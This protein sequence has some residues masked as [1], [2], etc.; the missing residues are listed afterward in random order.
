MEAEKKTIGEILRQKKK[1]VI[2]GVAAFI[3]VAVC[4][5]L[6]LIR[7][8]MQ[9]GDIQGISCEAPKRF[10]ME[11]DNN[12]LTFSEQT[13]T[14]E[15][16]IYVYYKDTG[17]SL[18]EEG[19]VDSLRNSELY[20]DKS[21]AKGKPEFKRD[22]KSKITPSY[23]Y[24]NEDLSDKEKGRLSEFTLYNHGNGQVFVGITISGSETD[25]NN[26]KNIFNKVKDSVKLNEEESNK[27]VKEKTDI[28]ENDMSQLKNITVDSDIDIEKAKAS[29]AALN[30]KARE[31]LNSEEIITKAEK[32]YES[33]LQEAAAPAINA[34]GE[35]GKVTLKSK[36]AI[37][38]AEKLYNDLPLKVQQKVSNI[39]VMARA[40]EKHANLI[41][42]ESA[43]K[44][45]TAI[46]A[47]N[48]VTLDSK[49]AIEKAEKLYEGAKEEVKGKV[50]NYK[51]LAN[52]RDTYDSLLEK[53]EKEEEREKIIN[54]S[55]TPD[56]DELA[57]YPQKYEGQAV[58]IRGEVIQALDGVYRVNINH[59][60][61]RWTDTVYVTEA[62]DAD[63]KKLSQGSAAPVMGNLSLT[64]GTPAIGNMATATWPNYTT[65]DLKIL[66]DDIV[67]IY[68]TYEGL[69]TYTSVLGGEITIPHINA[70]IIEVE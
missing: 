5:T 43:A 35:I 17:I 41:D 44:I 26:Y 54:E 27:L 39:G 49:K 63:V 7:E 70:E 21:I 64:S 42:E 10:I 24:L 31:G 40:R 69:K 48:E 19:R 9:S 3:A 23:I 45:D 38:K 58:K 60:G 18:E 50:K 32:D 11:S 59:N 53:K 22:E 62:R 47:I 36:E 25:I 68:G 29:L 57:R 16:K 46:N 6:V 52:A 14:A 65:R 67:I 66:E 20:P 56:Y 15:T 4:I 37:E 61:Y 8:P 13:E 55:I 33:L 30:T 28:H 34:I 12:M 1:I 51:K 2:I